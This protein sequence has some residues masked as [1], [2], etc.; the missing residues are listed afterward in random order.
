MLDHDV[1][2]RTLSTALRAGG[3]L[4][5]IFVED[6]A[7]SNA[8][9]DDGKVENL[10]SGRD[11]GAGI[12][13]IVGDT[14]GFAHTADLSSEGLAQAAEA[15]GA[16]ARSGGGGVVEVALTRQDAPRP[17][18]IAVYPEDVAKATKVD[19]LRRADATARA[20]GSAI[21]QVT[22]RY[23]DSRRRILIANSD[24][25]G[26]DRDV[27][28]PGRV[29]PGEGHLDDPAVARAGRRASCFG[30]LGQ[31]R[32][33]QVRGVGE[34]G[35]VA[36]DDPD[37]GPAVPPGAEVLHLA[38]VEDGVGARLVLDEDLGELAARSKGGRQGALDEVVVEHR[39]PLGWPAKVRRIVPR[40]P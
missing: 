39:A 37:P 8:N 30:R 5:E 17:N 4:A 23:G 28:G 10:S 35:G 25:L 7:S 6:K 21:T 26:V 40:C 16:A 29:L 14:T 15:A 9:F 20:A 1:I 24:G 19:L 27:V 38:V 12:R 36:H 32:R 18:D 2:Q 31:A 33:R 3:E 22:A 11:R 34:P 13:V